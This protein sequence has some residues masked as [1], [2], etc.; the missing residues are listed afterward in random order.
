MTDVKVETKSEPTKGVQA[1]QAPPAP[2]KACKEC[3]KDDSVH[4]K[5]EL[6]MTCHK[7]GKK[8]A[9]KVWNDYDHHECICTEQSQGQCPWHGENFD[10]FRCGG[11][12][13]MDCTCPDD[14][15]IHYETAVEY[16]WVPY[17]SMRDLDY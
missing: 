3:K 4:E 9:R 7:K 8:A 5:S 6:C 17:V 14:L 10:C 1:P 11:N 15:G 12:S 13:E 16:G 2:R